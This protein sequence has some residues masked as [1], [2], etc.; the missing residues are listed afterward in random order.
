MEQYKGSCHCGAI[1]FSFRAKEITSGLRCNCSLCN[2][3]GVN[4]ST[5]TLPSDEIEINAKEGSLSIYAFG[6][7][8][9]KHYFCKCCGI[10]PFNKSISKVGQYRINLGCIEGIDSTTLPFEVFNGAEIQ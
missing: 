3:K 9:A 7:G 6:S 2:R 8:V 4:V 5:F 1:K 10:A